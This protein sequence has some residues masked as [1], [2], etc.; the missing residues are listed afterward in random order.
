MSSCPP[1]SALDSA[2]ALHVDSKCRSLDIVSSLLLPSELHVTDAELTAA[3]LVP[4][5]SKQLVHFN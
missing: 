5:Q 2:L 4:L 1:D 3:H